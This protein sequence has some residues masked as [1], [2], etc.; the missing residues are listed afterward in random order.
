MPKATSHPLPD[1]RQGAQVQARS[2]PWAGHSRRIGTGRGAP[3][4]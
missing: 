3:Q 1:D 2:G 4:A